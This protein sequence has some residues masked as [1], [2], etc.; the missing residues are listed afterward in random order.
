MS[1]DVILDE[2]R[3]AAKAMIAKRRAIE[4]MKGSSSIK[5]DRVDEALEE[6]DDVRPPSPC[7]HPFAA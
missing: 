5:A 6:L 4:R 7:L 3:N 2:H 1:R